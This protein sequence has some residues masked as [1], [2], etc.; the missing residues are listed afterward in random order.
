VPAHK[1]A[2]A[3]DISVALCVASVRSTLEA[4]STVNDDVCVIP[5]TGA[6]PKPAMDESLEAHASNVVPKSAA[7][8]W[9]APRLMVSVV[10]TIRGGEGGERYPPGGAGGSGGARGGGGEGRGVI[11]GGGG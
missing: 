4:T 9:A 1:A 2:S 5:T 8:T 6:V 10:W 3:L 7:D 11:G